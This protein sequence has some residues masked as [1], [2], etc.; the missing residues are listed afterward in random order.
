MTAFCCPQC[1]AT[2]AAKEESDPITVASPWTLVR[3]HELAKTNEPPNA[4]ELDF[5]RPLL[6]KIAARL[7]RLDSEMTQLKDQLQRL[8]AE[9]RK[10]AE[11]HAQHA[12]VASPLRRV[13]PEILSEIFSWSL[14][15]IDEVKWDASALKQSPW[16][17]TR[18]SSLWRRTAIS[19]PSLWSSINWSDYASPPPPLPMIQAQVDRARML[20]ISF[21]AH[22][23][24]EKAT[25]VKVFEFLSQHSARWVDLDLQMTAALVPHLAALRGRLP[26][27]QRLWL[28][29]DTEESEAAVDS[30]DCFQTASSLVGSTP[31]HASYPSL[32]PLIDSPHIVS[33]G[34]GSATIVSLNWLQTLLKQRL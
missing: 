26:S 7:T 15:A 20:R 3:C 6:S 11:Y 16:V 34:H 28:Q 25:Q 32:S 2:T 24:K 13:P 12:P 33:V 21:S 14:P 30:M 27:L 17:L 5:M 23:S 18:V 4:A 19:I 1:G 9:R 10:L 31:N 8:E 29:W 22:E